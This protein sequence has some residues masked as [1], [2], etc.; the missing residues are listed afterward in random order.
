MSHTPAP[1][2]IERV[3]GVWS[4]VGPGELPICW[5]APIVQELR[6]EQIANMQVMAAAVELLEAANLLMAAASPYMTH[7]NAKE[8]EAYGALRAAIAK[9]NG[10]TS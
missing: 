9:A 10:S 8:R 7:R 5:F 4:V 2:R 1:W 6:E 3:N